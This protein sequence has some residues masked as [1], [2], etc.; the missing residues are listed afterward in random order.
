MDVY[1]R[2][3]DKK[4]PAVCFEEAPKRLIGEARV[5]VSGSK[6][7]SARYDT[8]Y[9]RNG[10]CVIFMPP[11]PIEG[12]RRAEVTERRTKAGF[13]H[14]I[15]RLITVDFPDAE[16]I[17]LVLDNLNIHTIGSLYKAFPP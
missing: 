17:I 13:A 10:A 15:K 14:Q 9:K 8:G 4:R 12:W 11:A 6:G 5:S 16:K 1:T 3:H 2:K 7:K